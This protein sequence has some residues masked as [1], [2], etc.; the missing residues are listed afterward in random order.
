MERSPQIPQLSPRELQLI[1]YA[2]Q[3]FTDTAI[4]L[5]LGISEATVG[6]YW[7]RVRI[8]IGPYNRTELVSIFLRSQ[9]EMALN[10]LR[11]KNA[12]LVEELQGAV[13]NVG[14]GAL[15][16]DIVENAP[17]AM[18]LVSEDGILQAA[19][20]AARELFGYGEAKMEG[21]SILDLIPER[22]RER[23][24][25]HRQ[26]YVRDPRRRSMGEHLETPALRKDGT[27]FLVRASLSAIPTPSGLLVTCVLR[28]VPSAPTPSGD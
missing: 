3:G 13:T 26:E 16:L 2:A 22:Y 5:K 24:R 1:E 23:H 28:E 9:Q 11:E 6:T 14:R 19:N 18:L 7:G 21:L 12:Q 15:Y 10:E 27:E 25:E 8:K 20:A 4:A 17:D